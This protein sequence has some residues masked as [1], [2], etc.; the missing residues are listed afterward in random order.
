M[1]TNIK[2]EAKHRI[3]NLITTLERFKQDQQKLRTSEAIRHL[4][5]EEVASNKNFFSNTD[6][7]ILNRKNIK[8]KITNK[9]KI[10]DDDIYNLID[11]ELSSPFG[12]FYPIFELD[13]PD[14][15][16][17]NKKI[18]LQYSNADF[19]DTIIPPNLVD[20]FSSFLDHLINLQKYINEIKFDI[21]QAIVDSTYEIFRLN[22][23]HQSLS[24][25]H[26]PTIT[27]RK[28]ITNIDAIKKKEKNLF[29]KEEYEKSLG[30]TESQLQKIKDASMN[31][32]IIFGEPGSGKTTMLRYL[33]QNDFK[34]KRN[35]CIIEDS[36]ELFIETNI[37]LI[38]NRDYSIKKLF[39][40][41]LR[42]N[43]SHLIIGETRT[44]EIVDILESA[45]TF[46]I[47]TTIHANSLEKAIERI[48]FMAR[49]RRLSKS[50]IKDLISA[51]IHMFIWMDNKKVAKAWIKNDKKE[52]SSIFDI[53]EEIL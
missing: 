5:E 2:E 1:Q 14:I 12:L 13:V 52:A 19:L 25:F 20:I 22:M 50:D 8:K 6:V 27:V 53:Y 49:P 18:K 36:A 39:V 40:A 11:A 47:G 7:S 51:S 46:S 28:H 48:Y 43:P 17:Q 30:I 16:I 15:I 45:L 33:I 10:A 24:V 35:V 42:Q 3:K 4:V 31:S 34:S 44:E 23:V 37:S 38:T 29:N 26:T 21:S 9:L 41:A 32:F